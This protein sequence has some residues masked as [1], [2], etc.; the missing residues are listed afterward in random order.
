VV[1]YLDTDPSPERFAD[2]R[3]G[4]RTYDGH[5]GTDFAVRDAMAMEQGVDVLAA[6]DG[7]VLRLREGVRDGSREEIDGRWPRTKAAARGADRSR[8]GGRASH[9]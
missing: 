3:C 9:T 7:T 2:F 5:D 1:N 4:R 6:A 8:R